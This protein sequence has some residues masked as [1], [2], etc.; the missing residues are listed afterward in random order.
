MRQHVKAHQ[1]DSVEYE[2]LDRMSQINVDMDTE[3]KRVLKTYLEQQVRFY[4]YQS[5][6][7]AL[8]VA[9][10]NGTPVYHQSQ[11]ILYHKIS[12][13]LIVNRWI[14]QGRFTH[15]DTNTIDWVEQQKAMKLSTATRKRFISKW[16]SE[17]APTGKNMKRWKLRFKSNCPFCLYEDEDTN[18]ILTCPH[19]DA[20]RIWN[21]ALWKLLETL[22]KFGT[23]VTLLF[24]L[25][26]ELF[27]WRG[28]N[29]YLAI[30]LPY[31]DADRVIV[32]QQN[33]GWRAFLDGLFVKDWQRYQTQF[34]DQAGIT[35]CPKLWVSKAIRACWDFSTTIW[36][37]RNKQL[38]ETIRIE[39]LE[40]KDEIEQAIKQEH[41]LGLSALPTYGFS[42]LFR[43]KLEKLLEEDMA[44]KREW[45][46]IVKQGRIVHKDSRQLNDEFEN[47]GALKKYLELV[48]YTEEELAEVDDLLVL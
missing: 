37:G 24:L 33:L 25:Q 28:Y 3:A 7:Y 10:V 8:P 9:T 12:R 16:V 48:E 26:Q 31:N 4:S 18:H 22:A 34:F 44:S 27:A 38:H 46:A 30:K 5:H 19:Q 45:L 21:E 17:Y 14:K 41:R 32:L 6:E 20:E 35:K 40:G 23:D 11:D 15:D 1:D 13:K 47:D 42:Y 36:T 29:P 2:Q 39:Q 43:M